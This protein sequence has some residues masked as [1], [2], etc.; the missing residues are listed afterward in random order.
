MCKVNGEAVL[1]WDLMS[2]RRP[3]GRVSPVVDAIR[4]QIV[5]RRI[6]GYRLAKDT[7]LP[8]TTVQ[9]FLKAYS[10]PTLSTLEAIA[11]AVGM[12]VKAQED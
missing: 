5:K 12:T 10:S 6:S 4:R 9:R 11:A 3:T 1:R 7:G 8:L 2:G